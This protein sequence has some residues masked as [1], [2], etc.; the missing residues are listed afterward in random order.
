MA[1]GFTIPDRSS[2]AMVFSGLSA[3]TYTVLVFDVESNGLPSGFAADSELAKVAKGL[4][5][6]QPTGRL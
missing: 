4:D 6:H 3:D 2:K 5:E 1:V